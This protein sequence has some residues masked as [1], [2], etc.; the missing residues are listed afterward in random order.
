MEAAVSPIV[1]RRS[2]S[3]G[4]VHAENIAWNSPSRLFQ[5]N[6]FKADFEIST[7]NRQGW[8]Y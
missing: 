1:I 5:H 8:R 3:I 7:S 6:R 2:A 4:N